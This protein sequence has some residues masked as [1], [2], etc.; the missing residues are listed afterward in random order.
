MNN[1]TA[2]GLISP[3]YTCSP[4]L[5]LVL[6]YDVTPLTMVPEQVHLHGQW[7][8][9][10]H[11]ECPSTEWPRGDHVGVIFF[12]F[13]SSPE[14]V[15]LVTSFL[16]D[17]TVP[18]AFVLQPHKWSKPGCPLADFASLFSY[19]IVNNARNLSPRHSNRN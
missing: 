16:L 19:N 13:F 11:Q 7:L 5:L 18:T 3:H 4:T 15:C 10:R 2:S 1:V 9:K 8:G 17:I 12:T 14:N 6:F